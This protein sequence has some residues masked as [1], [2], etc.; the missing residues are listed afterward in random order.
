MRSTKRWKF[1][2]LAACGL[3]LLGV[4]GAASA[5]T[6]SA[7]TS[8]QATTLQPGAVTVNFNSGYSGTCGSSGA[9]DCSGSFKIVSGSQSGKYAKPRLASGKYLTVPHP[10]QGPVG[11][12]KLELGT[13]SNYFGLYWGSIDKYN[14]ISFYNGTTLVKSYTGQAIANLLGLNANGNS[15]SAS[16]NRYIN[17]F[18]GS[19]E[20]FD[21][22]KL[23]STSFAFESDNHAFTPVPLPAA[24]WLLLSGLLGVGVLGRRRAAGK[25]A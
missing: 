16:S 3:A 9:Y 23:T 13:L 1:P 18:F 21:T 22:V 2:S 8:S 25:A 6:V 5:L 7:G 10:Q 4:S 24:A 11:T 17:F 14:K 20:Y 19:G 15:S 12:A